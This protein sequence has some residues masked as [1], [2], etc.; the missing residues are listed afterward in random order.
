M[1][2]FIFFQLQ[3]SGPLAPSSHEM[4][5]KPFLGQ[6][7]PKTQKMRERREINMESGKYVREGWGATWNEEGDSWIRLAEGVIIPGRHPHN[8]NFP[9]LTP[10]RELI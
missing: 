3:A 9:W 2:G 1:I 7:G 6:C 5:Y 4:R 8:N 10:C